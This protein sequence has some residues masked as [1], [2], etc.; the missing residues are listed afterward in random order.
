M[1]KTV[2]VKNLN[3]TFRLSKKQM[4]LDKTKDAFKVAVN[5]LSFETYKGE[6]YG[7]LGPNGAGKTTTLRCIATLISPDSGKITIDGIDIKNAKEIK[8]KIC[9][10]TGELKLDDGFTPNYLFDFFAKLYGLNDEASQNR[11]KE[12]FDYFGINSF[13]EVKIGDLSTGM[14]QKVSICI[15]LIHDPE[16]II[17]DEPTNGL[18]VLTA[19]IVTDY[20]LEM[21]KQNKTVILSTHVMSLVEK[22]CD[23]V[24]IIINGK[25]IVSDTVSN[26][27]NQVESHDMEDVFFN[28]YKE[29][30]GE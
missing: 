29:V 4:R 27:L 3:K 9:F 22:L 21:K 6:I 5:D 25:V 12:L 7:L 13:S 20:L 11:K 14:K 23:R 2:E 30:V 28:I 17:Y 15:S 16:I 26:L 18:D 24:G 8:R 19:R 1:E 10:L